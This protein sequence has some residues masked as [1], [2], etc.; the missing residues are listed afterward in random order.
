[1]LSKVGNR[2]LKFN[3][4]TK[5][6]CCTARKIKLSQL[7][8]PAQPLKTLLAKHTPNQSV[9]YRK[10]GNATMHLENGQRVYFTAANV[11]QIVLNPPATTLTAFFTLCQNYSF[12]KTL[13]YPKLPTDYTWSVKKKADIS[14][15]KQRVYSNVTLCHNFKSMDENL[16]YFVKMNIEH[17]RQRG[18]PRHDL[19]LE[20]I[21]H[22]LLEDNP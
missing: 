6:M 4:E 18:S 8:E 11:Q 3:E 14:I 15:Q 5:G 22:E 16:K 17:L 12:A 21:I 2:A 13:L 19:I 20:K 7:E 1:M 10:S 9:S